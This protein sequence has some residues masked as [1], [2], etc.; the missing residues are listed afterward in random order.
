MEMRSGWQIARLARTAALGWAALGML[1]A[2]G[3]NDG[4]VE[5]GRYPASGRGDVDCPDL[6]YAVRV[7]GPDPH[8][9]DADNDG[10]GC[11]RYLGRP[12]PDS[13]RLP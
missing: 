12:I 13:A 9:L 5:L 6:G 11:D 8:I 3:R 2:C 7:D 1:A 10:I 4:G